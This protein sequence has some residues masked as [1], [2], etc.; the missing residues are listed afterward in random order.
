MLMNML[1]IRIKI[2]AGL[3]GLMQAHVGEW[4]DLRAAEDVTMRRGDYRRIPLG[5]AME[6]PD[7][8]EAHILPRSSTFERYGIM[9]TNGMGIIDSLYRGDNDWWNFGAYAV[10]DTTIRKNDR[11]CQF[12]IVPV[13]PEILFDQVER[14][15]NED[16]G[17]FGSSGL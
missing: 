6:L 10:R 12:R 11:I 15:G 4:Y 17:G 5:V 2:K 16:R 3:E 7:G 1:T 8:Y 9:L 14:L 13:Q